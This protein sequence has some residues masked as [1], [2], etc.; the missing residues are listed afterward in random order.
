LVR[1]EASGP[2]V[3]DGTISANGGINASTDRYG[4]GAGGGIYLICRM[5]SGAGNGLL[6]ATGGQGGNS[7]GGAGGGGRIAVWTTSHYWDGSLPGQPSNNLAGSTTGNAAGSNG[8]FRLLIA[9]NAPRVSNTTATNI[10]GTTADLIGTLTSTGAAATTVSV[11]WGTNDALDVKANWQTNATVGTCGIGPVTNSI[12]SLMAGTVYYY[13][14]YATNA[15]GEDWSGASSNLATAGL[16]DCNNNG[17]ATAIT[18]TSATLRGYASGTPTPSVMVY[19]GPTDGGTNTTAWSNAVDMGSV[20]NTAFQ[21]DITGL[22][23]NQT[24]YYRCHATNINGV[25]W[26]PVT[27]FFTGLD[28]V[29]ISDAQTLKGGAGTSTSATFIVSLAATSVVD[30]AFS[31]TTSNGTAVAGDGYSPQSGTIV[32]PAG[33]VSTSITVAVI[34]NDR[35]EYPS[36]NFYLN[37][38]D[39]ACATFARAQGM[40]TINC[41]DNISGSFFTSVGE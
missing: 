18:L 16:P 9:P 28:P 4:G 3:V 39:P 13:R 7:G 26:T 30:V 27:N 6:S 11:Y 22:L 36:R 31:F 37:L 5:F 24:N 32:L 41:I 14:F 21:T 19:W 34:G 17:G 23:A 38:S 35:D 8:T 40:C 29:S 15:Y 1:I 20:F 2:I 12:G 25:R 10:T 33:A